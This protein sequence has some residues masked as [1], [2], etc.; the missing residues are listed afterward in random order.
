M[1]HFFMKKYIFAGIFLLI[2]FTFGITNFMYQFDGMSIAFQKYEKATNQDDVKKLISKIEDT[3]NDELVGKISFIETYGYIQKLLGKSEI[4]NFTYGKDKSG[5]L[6]YPSFYREDDAKLKE[7]AKQIRRLKE[8]VASKETE[9]L[10]INPPGKYVPN[11]SLYDKGF[12]VSDTNKIQDEFLLYLQNNS[13]ETLDLRKP[14]LES[15]LPYEKLFYKTDHHW[16]I[17]AAF[18]GFCAIVDDMESRYG[19]QLDPNKFYRDLNNY[20]IHY[21]PQSMLGSMGRNSGINYSGL[22]DFTFI[23]P[24]FE[25]NLVWEA[26]DLNGDTKRKEGSF[27]ESILQLDLLSSSK[28]YSVSKYDT[29]I[30]TINPWDKITN[31]NNPDGPK[32]LC[33]RD[34]YFSPTLSFLAPLCSEIHMIWP[35]ATTNKVDIEKYLEENNFDYVFIELYPGNINEE[36]FTFF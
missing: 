2:L 34:S 36:A 11:I 15:G 24:K 9:T 28:I 17:E 22:D 16:T 33:I 31:K 26:I 32:I 14:I 25:T 1:K 23:T 19:V 3:A 27:E 13:V 21:Y 18:L 7:Y 6:N 20:N 35:L 30:E 4:D 29:Y 10:F 12:P 5:Y 8:S